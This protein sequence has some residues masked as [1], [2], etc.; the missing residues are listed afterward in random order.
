[1]KVFRF[2]SKEEFDRLNNGE[3]LI[4]HTNHKKNGLKTDSIGFCFFDEEEIDIK[5][6]IHFLS[7][8][9]SFDICAVFETDKNNLKQGYGIYAKPLRMT[10]ILALDLYNAMTNRE[11][12]QRTEYS[13]TTYNNSKFKLIKY[14]E[15]IWSQYKP[16]EEQKELMWKEFIIKE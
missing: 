8:I 2:M 10:G 1:M 13:T 6:A 9:V 15:N 11:K 3:I 14:S 5:E 7:G 4:N 16:M 12:I